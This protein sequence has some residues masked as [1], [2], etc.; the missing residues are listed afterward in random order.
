M[1]QHSCDKKSHR[2]AQRQPW[3]VQGGLRMLQEP[4]RVYHG[5]GYGSSVELTKAAKGKYRQKGSENNSWTRGA[6]RQADPHDQAQG[7]CARCC[8]GCSPSTCF[9]LSAEKQS[10]NWAC[11]RGGCRRWTQR[12]PAESAPVPS[13][14]QIQGP[15]YLFFMF[16]LQSIS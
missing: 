8:P 11:P 7:S 12:W 4:I 6:D 9:S 15:F 1:T 13:I 2:V 16:R 3:V 14:G 10:Q 5:P